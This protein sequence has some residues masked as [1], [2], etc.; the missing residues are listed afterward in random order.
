MEKFNY[1]I[2]IEAP[3][4]EIAENLMRYYFRENQVSLAEVEAAL[5]KQKENK[6]KGELEAEQFLRAICQFEKTLRIID[7]C[8]NDP[9]LIDKIAEFLKINVQPSKKAA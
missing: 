8:V 9:S 5:K 2:C 3:N 1:T 4:K 7:L 6:D